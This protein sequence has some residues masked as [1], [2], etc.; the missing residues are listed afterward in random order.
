MTVSDLP[1]PKQAEEKKEPEGP[2]AVNNILAGLSGGAPAAPLDLNAL[3]G[4]GAGGANP[5]GGNLLGAL[6]GSNGS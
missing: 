6:T 3:M 1:V 5:L 2:P 4:G